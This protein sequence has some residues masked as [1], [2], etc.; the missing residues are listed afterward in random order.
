MNNLIPTGL[1]QLH[2]YIWKSIVLM[3]HRSLSPKQRHCNIISLI[4][5]KAT[6]ILLYCKIV[7]VDNAR[8]EVITEMVQ[9]MHLNGQFIECNRRQFPVL[10]AFTINITLG[11]PKKCGSQSGYRSLHSTMGSYMLYA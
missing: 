3:L 6:N 7:S 10:P 2:F 4:F 5:I 11:Q 9:L 1:Y 8:D